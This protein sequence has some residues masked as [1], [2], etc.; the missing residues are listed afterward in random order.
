M[1][2]DNT[3]LLRELAR[4]KAAF[5]MRTIEAILCDGAQ[6]SGDQEPIKKRPADKEA[7]RED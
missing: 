7:A 6:S 5:Q 4:A 3:P 2:H 1:T